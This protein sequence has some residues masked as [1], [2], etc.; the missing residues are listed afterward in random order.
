MP[1]RKSLTYFCICDASRATF[2]K[3][4]QRRLGGALDVLMA[5][6]RAVAN[7]SCSTARTSRALE[8]QNLLLHPIIMGTNSVSSTL[9]CVFRRWDLSLLSGSRLVVKI[10]LFSSSMVSRR[11]VRNLSCVL[12]D[13]LIGA[14]HNTI[15]PRQERQF[16]L[17][18]VPRHTVLTRDTG[19]HTRRPVIWEL[20]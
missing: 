8:Q 18:L 13:I 11:V 4:P 12:L 7:L 19:L 2:G 14:C 15:T 10:G 3:R 6:V 5:S 20:G 16:M 1:C 9:I 17:R